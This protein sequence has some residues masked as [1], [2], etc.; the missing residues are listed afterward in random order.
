MQKSD[1]ESFGSTIRNQMIYS[2]CALTNIYAMGTEGVDKNLEKLDEY[3]VKTAQAY[4]LFSKGIGFEV[5]G[6]L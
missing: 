2:L 3:A 4:K 1:I 5:Q 6:P